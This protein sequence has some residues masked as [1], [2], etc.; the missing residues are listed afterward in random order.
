[1]LLERDQ[2][3]M[4]YL[5]HLRHFL[6]EVVPFW[7]MRPD[8]SLIH[9]SDQTPGH[10]PR[11]LATQERDIIAVYFPVG[12]QAVLNLPPGSTYQAQWFDPRT[13]QTQLSQ[14]QLTGGLAAVTAPSGQDAHGHPL[15]Y[16]SV[17]RRTA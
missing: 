5:L 13:A 4:V 1:M 16:V 15:D 8:S 7:H 6:T 2:A 12:G 17:M 11:A 3:G 9:Q 14:T 10:T